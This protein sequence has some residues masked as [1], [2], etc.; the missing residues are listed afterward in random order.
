MERLP[1]RT[2]QGKLYERFGFGTIGLKIRIQKRSGKK[3]DI[4]KEDARRSL[5]HLRYQEARHVDG[6]LSGLV[7]C[8]FGAR[9]ELESVLQHRKVLLR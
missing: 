1:Y 4:T 3:E 9:V 6:L 8:G 7:Q 2:D 5:K